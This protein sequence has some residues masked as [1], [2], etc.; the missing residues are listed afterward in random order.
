MDNR[1]TMDISCQL[2][3][4]L[5]TMSAD[6]D[7]CYDPINHFIVLLLLHAIVGCIGNIFSMLYPIQIMKFFLRT[8]QGDSTT[9][10][11]GRGKDN[12]L[13][14]LC[15]GNDAAPVCW[16]MLSFVLVINAKVLTHA[17]YLQ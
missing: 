15:Q 11:G 12:P 5:A 13:Q 8:T 10:M 6:A 1:L 7:K 14:G 2:W 4:P 9:F 17:S 16:L 3:H